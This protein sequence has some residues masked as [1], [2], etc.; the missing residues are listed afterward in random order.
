MKYIVYMGIRGHGYPDSWINSYGIEAK[1]IVDAKFKAQKLK[2][3][4]YAGM[5][6]VGRTRPYHTLY[7]DFVAE[8]GK[9]PTFTDMEIAL[10]KYINN[11]VIYEIEPAE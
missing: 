10:R 7:Y 5:C 4:F 8:T 11:E 3:E 1:N 6:N 2:L 9:T